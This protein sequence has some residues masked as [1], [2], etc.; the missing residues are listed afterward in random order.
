MTDFFSPCITS[1]GSKSAKIVA[2]G[3]APGEQEE[4]TGVPFMGSS[5]QLLDTL[6]EQA[7]LHR[8]DMYL[9]NVLWTRPP[10]NK[11]EAFC[12]KK[13]ELPPG[14]FL[15]AI[16]QGKYLHPSL[17]REV[18][19]LWAELREV[20]P[21]LILALGAKASWA[22]LGRS[23]ITQIRGTIAE[24]PWG[25]VLPTFH[26]ANL[27][28]AWDNYTIVV[29]DLKKAAIECQFPEIRRPERY[30][31]ID[32]TLAEVYAWR[33]VALASRLLAVDSETRGGTITC[34]G[35]ASSKS[36]AFV[37]PFF[38][39]RKPGGSYWGREEEIQVRQIINSVLASPVPKLFQNGLYDMQYLLREGYKL[40]NCQHDT[41]ILQ[42]A[43]YPEMPKSL[44]FLGSIHTNDQ[45]WK[46][47]RPRGE[48]ALKREDS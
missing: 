41:M 31:V 27:F 42:H 37:V 10:G 23:Q 28:H 30:V 33:E 15:P 4:F 26:P 47:L 21:N 2:V 44:A 1:I 12:V 43:L 24:S 3:E 9:T 16:S 40:C 46:L 45:A 32:P 35:F 22:I 25:K 29:Q 14:Y 5:G 48:E 39:A 36:D 20:K 19:R 8:S 17:T 34:L 13:G 18:D 7:G 6:L 38:D 11:F